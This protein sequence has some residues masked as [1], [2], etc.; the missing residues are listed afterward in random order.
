MIR[1]A[2]LW[3]CAIGYV[4]KNVANYSNYPNFAL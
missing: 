1:T 2:L 4:G 3:G